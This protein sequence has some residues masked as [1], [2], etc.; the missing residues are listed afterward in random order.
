MQRTT[1][2]LP[3]QLP[4][5]VERAFS[6][7]QS[8]EPDEYQDAQVGQCDVQ[9]QLVSDI[10]LGIHQFFEMP[11]PLVKV[12]HAHARQCYDTMFYLR[13][14]D[15]VAG[16][17]D[18]AG[19]KT[20]ILYTKRLSLFLFSFFVDTKELSFAHSDNSRYHAEDRSQ[21]LLR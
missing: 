16:S 13:G 19:Q 4:S 8:I 5:P 20:G 17:A 18:T 1:S 14:I 12:P 10:V 7:T 6:S 11:L 3:Q 21:N 15:R 2:G 9:Q